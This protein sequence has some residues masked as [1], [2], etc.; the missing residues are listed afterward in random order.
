M[1]LWKSICTSLILLI[2][3]QFCFGQMK[4]NPDLL[5]SIY[6]YNCEYVL[7]YVDLL[8]DGLEKSPSSIGYIVINRQRQKSKQ[9]NQGGFYYEDIISL[10]IKRRNS[11]KNRLKIIRSESEKMKIDFYIASDESSKLNF[12]EAK[13]D[14]YIPSKPILFDEGYGGQLCEETLFRLNTFSEI[15]TAHSNA[16]GHFVI[17]AESF[18]DFPK[19]KESIMNEIIKAGIPVNRFKF[20]FRRDNSTLYPYAKLW[21]IPKRKK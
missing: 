3:I 15:L 12:T 4:S 17:Y 8:I 20:F 10:Q 7:Q 2:C 16:R 21:L 18:K 19:E 13:W 11:D 6:P 14:L 1:K 5:A 9:F